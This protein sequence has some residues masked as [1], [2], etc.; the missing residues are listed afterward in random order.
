MAA[1]VS[2]DTARGSI[3]T[4]VRRV[5]PSSSDG[6]VHRRSCLHL[7]MKPHVV[8]HR[9]SQPSRQVSAFPE[10]GTSGGRIAASIGCFGADLE[11]TDM[12]ELGS[13]GRARVGGLILRSEEHTSELQ[14]LMSI[15]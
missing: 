12:Q 10:P 2:S 14:S 7:N 1:A 13:G 3:V 4:G 11:L 6:I 5:P 8:D 15:S 9:Q